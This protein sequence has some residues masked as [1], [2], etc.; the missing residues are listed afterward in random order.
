M[1]V[2]QAGCGYRSECRHCVDHCLLLL[3]LVTCFL[4]VSLSAGNPSLCTSRREYFDVAASLDMGCRPRS[5]RPVDGY[6]LPPSSRIYE[7]STPMYVYVRTVG[8]CE[9]GARGAL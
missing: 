6:V 1:S 7:T 4:Q 5:P 8:W 9:V 2:V 3:R